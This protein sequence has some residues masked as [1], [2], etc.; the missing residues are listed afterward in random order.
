VAGAKRA[1]CRIENCN[2]NRKNHGL[3]RKH[4]AEKY[5]CKAEN[6]DK[7]RI[8]GRLCFLHGGKYFCKSETLLCDPL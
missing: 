6:C 2:N 3:C 5:I 4:G 8:K 1:K 7:A